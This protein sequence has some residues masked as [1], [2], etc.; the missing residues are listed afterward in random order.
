M[1][2][3]GRGRGRGRRAQK[4]SASG[5][6]TS[7]ASCCCSPRAPLYRGVPRGWR[8]TALRAPW[9]LLAAGGRGTGTAQGTGC[10]VPPRASRE[11]ACTAGMATELRSEEGDASAWDLAC[12]FSAMPSM[13]EHGDWLNARAMKTAL[14]ITLGAA[15]GK[16]H[17]ASTRLRRLCASSPIASVAQLDYLAYRR[18]RRFRGLRQKPPST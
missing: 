13:P 9:S 8:G 11:V 10:P 15:P 2:S 5:H 7:P 1:L 14:R 16:E 18:P 17:R 6:C 4:R 12:C 3:E